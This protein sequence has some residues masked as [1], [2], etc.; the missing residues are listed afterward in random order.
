MS[1]L[2]DS[3][4]ILVLDSW[5]LRPRLSNAVASRL[6]KAQ[7]L[8]SRFGL[9]QGAAL[10]LTHGAQLPEV[11]RSVSFEVAHF[12]GLTYLFAYAEGVSQ[13]SPGSRSAPWDPGRELRKTPTGFHKAACE[14]PLEFVFSS[15]SVP[16]VRYAT[17]GCAV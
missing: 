10:H 5:D 17:L 2:R 3:G 15:F 12:E 14:T 1:S 11:A 8:N 13:Q 4:F 9:L 16:R 7:L 6:S